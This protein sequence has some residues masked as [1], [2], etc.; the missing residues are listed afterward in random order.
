[1]DLSDL[2]DQLNALDVQVCWVREL[3]L[4]AVWV[5]AHRVLMLSAAAFG[6]DLLAACREMVRRLDSQPARFRPSL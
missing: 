2:I 6:D 3:S 5:H 1:M 4:P